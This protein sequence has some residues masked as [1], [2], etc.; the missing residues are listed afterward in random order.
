MKKSLY[1]WQLAG[2]IFTSI[3]GVLLHF[4]F[5]WT[6]QSIIIAPFSAVNESI[7]EHMKLLFFPM[8]IFAF[9]ESCYLSKEYKGFWCV[10]LTGI[11][12]GL[13]LIPVSYYTI[14]G[15]FG[16]IPG[17]MNIT[18]FFVTA[19]L[20]YWTET[21]ILKQP[22]ISCQ[23]PKAALLILWLIVLAFAVLT[24]VPPHIPL[25]EDSITKTYGYMK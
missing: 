7:W 25:F 11:A 3:T 5:D 23:S 9:V 13:G 21:R 6:G 16:M 12:L 2:F 10:K 17:W 24:F 20:V 18:I 4:L 15:I 1:T 8:F 19:A 22:N 14:R